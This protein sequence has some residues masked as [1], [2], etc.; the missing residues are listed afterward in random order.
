MNE[1][2]EKLIPKKADEFA[3]NYIDSLENGKTDY[4]FNKLDKQYQNEE[5]KAF[6]SQSYENLKDKDLISARIVNSEKRTVFFKNKTTTYYLSYEYEYS[7]NLWIYYNFQLLQKDN[8][9]LV[10]TFN[11]Q[12]TDHSLSETYKFSF[13]NKSFTHYLWFFFLILIPLFIVITLI[14]AIKTPLRRKWLW[15][16]F[17]LL[18]FSSFS[19]NWTTGE[20]G[21]Q[22]IR[23]HLLGAGIVKSGIIAPWIV[24][25]S[26]PL[27]AI[28]FWFK[29]QKNI[30]MVGKENND[31]TIE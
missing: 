30:N 5:A 17:I 13:E 19:L 1:I 8:D 28:L 12:P 15:I 24:S 2:P 29:R 11:I 16:I 9:F 23:F 18:G 22:L 20:F 31:T 10:Q 6:F 26:I 14:F 27:G 4:C 21:F 25:F 7:D 3:K